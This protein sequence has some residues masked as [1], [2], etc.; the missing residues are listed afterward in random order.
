MRKDNIR[1]Y[2]T[3]AFRYYAQL[4]CPTTDSYKK[5]IRSMAMSDETDPSKALLLAEKAE[6]ENYAHIMDI[7]AVNGTLS[8]LAESG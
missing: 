7:E 8:I 1:D 6:S 3:F 5:H 2:A 4:G